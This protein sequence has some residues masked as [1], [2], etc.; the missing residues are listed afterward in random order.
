MNDFDPDAAMMPPAE[1]AAYSNGWG[2]AKRQDAETIAALHEMIR[3]TRTR[4]EN[5]CN[6]ANAGRMPSD[7]REFMRRVQCG[8]D[9]LFQ[10]AEMEAQG[11]LRDAETT[12]RLREALNGLLMEWD[13][14]SRYGSPMAKA[15]NER[16]T[17]ARAALASLE[18]KY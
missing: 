6:E 8:F 12:A 4:L 7:A 2:A 5:Y 17:A 11:S 18:G 3:R 14:L 1:G 16:V 13:E 15:A 10:E 9:S